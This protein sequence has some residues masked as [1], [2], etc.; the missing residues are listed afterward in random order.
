MHIIL[1]ATGHIGAALTKILLELGEP[2]TAVTRDPQKG[3][4]LRQMGAHVAVVNVLDT[5]KLRRT[6]KQGKRL[7]LLNPPAPPDTDTAKE[8]FK[9]VD[10]IISALEGSGIE[11]VVAESTYG[12]QPGDRLGDLG[13]LYH[14]EQAL[15]ALSVPH[16]IIRGAYYMSNW[17]HALDTA[18]KEGVVHTL[19]PAEYKIPMVSPAD[20]AKVAAKLLLEPP[21]KGGLYYVEGPEP[22][23]SAEVAD[24]FSAALQRPVKAVTIPQHQWIP[25]LEK[26]GFSPE[27]AASMAAM[28]D[29]T[30]KQDFEMPDAP[31]RGET[32]LQEY[33]HRLVHPK[34]A[35]V[36]GG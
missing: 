13:V 20:I 16:T 23:S 9:T 15:D 5:E 22:Y 18:R 4:K 34:H 14:M 31:I 21:T 30:L 2:V 24:A 27:A 32:T 7:Y 33:I 3:E 8:E 35:P 1:G 29:I 19:Y 17:D 11:K 26:M 6:F 12:A 10:A 36:T 28:T 25:S